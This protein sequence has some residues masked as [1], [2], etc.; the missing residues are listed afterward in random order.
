MSIRQGRFLL[1]LPLVAL[2]AGVVLTTHAGS[3]A[4][5]SHCNPTT[6][7]NDVIC[8][9]DI[10]A[11]AS[12]EFSGTVGTEDV[13]NAEPLSCGGVQASDYSIDWGDG[14]T[15]APSSLGCNQSGPFL[16]IVTVPGTHTYAAAGSYTLTL[17]STLDQRSATSISVSATATVTGSSGSPVVGLGSSTVSFGDQ[18]VGS[19][20]SSQTLTISN[21]ASSGS[22]SLTVGQL[23]IAG[24]NAADFSL[25]SDGCSNTSVAPGGSCTVAVAF[26]PTQVGSRSASLS[27]P[28]NAASSP[29]TVAL[30]GNGT[31]AAPPT[32]GLSPS[33]VVF[34]DQ[35]VGSTSTT[36]MLTITN[37]ASRGSQSLVIGQLA[38]AGAN[39]GD[40]GLGTDGCSNKTVA[41]GASCAVSLTFAPTQVGSRT[42]SLSVPSNAASTPDTVSLSGNGTAA[43][44]ADVRLTLSGPSSASRGVQVTYVITVANAGP[45]T[46][47]NVVLSDP[48][49][50]GVSFVGVKTA[51]GA[52]T[53]SKA[54]TISCSLGDLAS[55]GSVGSVVSVKVTARIGG[56]VTDLAS[57]YSTSDGAGPATPD[58]NTANNWA[59]LTT[60][61]TK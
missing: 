12:T 47:H 50:A 46:A 35:L 2:M 18:L 56:S 3:A 19:T 7:A 34:G 51:K 39:S 53:I 14:S 29:D 42:A 24:T 23:S 9:V 36:H 54:G 61:V 10:T 15:S 60:A 33:S 11:G 1:R 58:P 49:P 4:A 48:V 13:S 31:A 17:T 40:F 30:S 55:G 28:T 27:I 6:P 21:T 16:I 37:T 32:V 22:Q 20:S 43:P 44:S 59:T 41:P 8:A 45:S 52:C 38:I 26:A 57:A 5:G 25:G